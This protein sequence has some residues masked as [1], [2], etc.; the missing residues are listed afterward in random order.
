MFNVPFCRNE[1]TAAEC[2]L[3]EILLCWGWKRI[4]GPR[5][6]EAG[7]LQGSC[8]LLPQ[9]VPG[10]HWFLLC[11]S[12]PTLLWSLQA[13]M[14]ATRKAKSLQ[15]ASRRT[16]PCRSLVLLSSPWVSPNVRSVW[17]APS[18]QDVLRCDEQ[19]GFPSALSLRYAL[20]VSSAPTC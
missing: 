15:L 17:R 20:G 4:L 8:P 5:E 10:G 7:D 19:R 1:R 2:V 9:R 6:H 16:S 18:V 11:T 13:G 3:I 14:S 12:W